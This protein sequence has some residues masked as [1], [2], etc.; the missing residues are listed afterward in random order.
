MNENETAR[1]L[2]SLAGIHLSAEREAALV[3]GLTGTK[4]ITEMLAS[5]DVA[6]NEPAAQFR[7]PPSPSR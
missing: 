6:A 3:A 1:L 2:V 7:A 5:V 4:R